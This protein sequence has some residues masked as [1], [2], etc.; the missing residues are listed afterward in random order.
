MRGRSSRRLLGGLIAAVLA[1]GSAPCA[2][3]ASAGEPAAETAKLAVAVRPKKA[4]RPGLRSPEY[5]R[6]WGLATVNAA[7]AVRSGASGRGVMIALV[8]CGLQDAQP[9]LALNVSPLSVDLV[10]DRKA[11]S[12]NDRHGSYVAG[13]LGSAFNGEGLLG[14]AYNATLLSV[15]ADFDGGYQGQCAFRRA[16]LVRAVDYAVEKGARII[17]LPLETR[18]PM[19]P[20]FEASLARAVEAGVVV[21]AAAGNEK[22]DQPTWP[23]RYAADPRF[24]GSV[25]AVGAVGYD[26]VMTAWSNRAGDAR[27][28]FVAAPGDRVITD[29]GVKLC[30][31]VSGTSFATPYVAGALALVMETRPEMTGREA[32]EL[33]L[34]SARDRGAPGAD[35]VY[36]RGV[37]D[38]GRAV[39]SAVAAVK[40][41]EAG[42]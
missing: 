14:V 26:G 2:I 9:E 32:A 13:P 7:P 36:G 27:Q 24:A 1:A 38:I 11:P 22:A 37:L 42:G 31:L 4:R 15:R 5:R 19:G 23:A 18:R 21:V 3:A 41:P 6:S 34:K 10:P 12:L 16:D 28:A 35:A 33:L 30:Y 8:D 25:L 20:A 17:V 29:C 40:E 39:R